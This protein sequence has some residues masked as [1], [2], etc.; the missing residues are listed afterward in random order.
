MV[1]CGRMSGCGVGRILTSVVP[2][3]RVQWHANA[4]QYQRIAKQMAVLSEHLARSYLNAIQTQ[5]A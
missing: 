4:D 3:S 5:L 2:K 1:E